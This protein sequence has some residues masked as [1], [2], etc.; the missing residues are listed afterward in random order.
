MAIFLVS[1]GFLIIIGLYLFL[2]K[3]YGGPAEAPDA[4]GEPP[5]EVC[6]RPAAREMT[7]EELVSEIENRFPEWKIILERREKV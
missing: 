3:L 1:I 5:A 6:C 4:D 2:N 7:L